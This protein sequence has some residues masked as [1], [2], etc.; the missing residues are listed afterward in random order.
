[1][2]S[3]H[4]LY[5]IAVLLWQSF[6]AVAQHT[7]SVDQSA[8]DSACGISI[9]LLKN[10]LEAT[11]QINQHEACFID[12]D[13]GNASPLIAEMGMSDGLGNRRTITK[14]V[15]PA[16]ILTVGE[17]DLEKRDGWTIFFDKVHHKPYDSYLAELSVRNVR[18]KSSGKRCT[19]EIDSLNAGPFKGALAFTFYANSPLIHV[20]GVVQ[21]DQDGR[22]IVYDA[23]IVSADPDWKRIGWTDLKGNLTQV[24]NMIA[25]AEVIKSRFRTVAAEAE[26]GSLAIFPT[27]HQ[28]FYPLDFSDNFGFNWAGRNYRDKS[29][30]LGLGIRLPLDG[31]KRYVPWFNAPPG[32]AQS[33]SFFLLASS[34]D[35]ES[36]LETV[37]Q[38]TRNDQFKKLPGSVTFSSHYH[39][40]H[41]LDL[42]SRQPDPENWKPD[43]ILLPN[44][45]IEPGFV[46]VFKGMNVEIVHL[47]EFHNSRT[48]RLHAGDRLPLLELMH[49][50][51]E[52]LSD[53]EFL[54]LPGEEP[55]VHLGGHW[56]SFFPKPVYWVLNNTEGRSF[57]EED[58]HY[59]RVYHLGSQ[60]ETLEL[61]KREGGL[62]WTAHPRIK[63]STGFPDQYKDQEFYRSDRFLGAAWKN[64]PTDLSKERLGDRV[65]QLQ[66]DMANWG[67]KKL[68]LGEV[69]V[70]KVNP[71]HEQYA[72][73]NVNYL[74]LDEIPNYSDG[75]QSVLDVLRNGQYF[76][77]TG[78]ILIT[79]FSLDGKLSGET[80]HV[81]DDVTVNVALEWTF[82]LNHIEII[83]GD[84]EH[85]YR[86]RIDLSDT[87]AFGEDVWNLDMDLSGRKWVRLEVWDVAKNGAFAPPV[88]LIN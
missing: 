85:V 88:W 60:A 44:D 20:E 18:V 68:V 74:R 16:F 59:G 5:L 49:N 46:K 12:F 69:D 34:G 73:M 39:I 10:G 32:S 86:H 72:H 52:R 30:R 11:W 48:P 25:E 28:Y 9:D 4:S 51:C 42:V 54:L 65:L 71:D 63:G 31:D 37:R 33:L 70:F 6:Y 7:V 83:S 41:T 2:K 77:T 75:W 1:M 62:L 47:A 82:P 58:T 79:D 53:K 43:Q 29:D 78:E 67:E 36:T 40:E 26:T 24:E 64:M 13:F 27:P 81:V 45:L 14:S 61:F 66:D 22:A 55:N 87:E 23:G 17:R 56:I 57:L 8:F 35:V 3:K 21:T 80:L 84:G 50:E 38:Y 15:D 76:T 19:V